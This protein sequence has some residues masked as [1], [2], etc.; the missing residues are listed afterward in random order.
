VCVCVCVHPR[1]CEPIAQNN[2]I[3]GRFWYRFPTGESG[4][5]VFSRVSVTHSIHGLA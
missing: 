4:A 1:G 5:D 2:G 3:A